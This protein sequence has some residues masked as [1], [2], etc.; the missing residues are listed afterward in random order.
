M[1]VIKEISEVNY[2]SPENY[3]KKISEEEFYKLIENGINQFLIKDDESTKCC[4]L[5]GCVDINTEENK[6]INIIQAMLNCKIYFLGIDFAVTKEL[7]HEKFIYV[8][9]ILSAFQ[10][11]ADKEGYEFNPPLT[12]FNIK[13]LLCRLGNH[14]QIIANDSQKYSFENQIKSIINYFNVNFKIASTD[15]TSII[16][17]PL[18]SINKIDSVQIISEVLKIILNKSLS[19]NKYVI[20]SNPNSTITIESKNDFLTEKQRAVVHYSKLR[21]K[22]FLNKFKIE[23]YTG[24]IETDNDESNDEKLPLTVNEKSNKISYNNKIIFSSE[25]DFKK[26]KPEIEKF[27]EN[28]ALSAKYVETLGNNLF[29]FVYNDRSNEIIEYITSL[30]EPDKANLFTHLFEDIDIITNFI[31]PL[32]HENKIQQ[33]RTTSDGHENNVLAIPINVSDI[34]LL[35]NKI[36]E[37]KHPFKLKLELHQNKEMKTTVNENKLLL[38]STFSELS[39]LYIIETRLRGLNYYF[40]EL[41][42][43]YSYV[44]PYQGKRSFWVEKSRRSAISIFQSILYIRESTSCRY[45]T[46][47]KLIDYTL[48]LSTLYEIEKCFPAFYKVSL[49]EEGRLVSLDIPNNDKNKISP[50]TTMFGVK[51]NNKNMDESEINDK[52]E[53][54]QGVTIEEIQFLNK[55]MLSKI[56][57][58]SQVLICG[59][60]EHH[61]LILEQY[62]NYVFIMMNL[63]IINLSHNHNHNHNHKHIIFEYLGVENAV[64]TTQQGIALK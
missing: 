48:A 45:L 18:S 58:F 29:E 43:N 8:F 64:S 14:Y 63:S 41:L 34:K 30:Y 49:V 60:D 37:F 62:S 28:Y 16:S 54:N 47:T 38:K 3:F 6:F 1:R 44:V 52:I 56:V 36:A 17:L 13:N 24:S 2:I 23:L 57:R 15:I 32:L 27:F 26:L 7:F 10:K 4:K 46:L 20:Y 21:V 59:N 50:R 40:E 25:I 19:N 55:N 35:K 42:S 61:T 5:F 11:K 33:I 22:E 51:K 31:K 53:K 39:Y 12:L 9:Y